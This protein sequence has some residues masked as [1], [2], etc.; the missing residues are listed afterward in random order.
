MPEKPN[1]ISPDSTVNLSI[2]NILW[3]LSGIVSIVMSILTYSYLDL[4]K[5]NSEFKKQLLEKTEERL[6]KMEDNIVDIKVSQ[7]GM[8]GDIRIILDRQNRDNPVITS[9][10]SVEQ[11][12]PPQL[13]N[14][15]ED[16]S[17]DTVSDLN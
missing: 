8:R 17:S 5:D 9:N 13:P 7:E 2:K 12:L 3:I 10:R 14:V 11:S 16:D 4:K 1:N 15:S 6:E